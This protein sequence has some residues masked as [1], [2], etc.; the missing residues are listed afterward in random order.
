MQKISTCLWF[1]DKAEEAVHFYLSIFKE[2]RI[3]ATSH[4]GPEGP[5]PEGTVLTIQFEI[6]GHEFEALN[7]GPHFAFTPAISLIVNCETQEEVDRYWEALSEGG[8]QEMCGWLKDRYG[9]SWQIVPTALG[10]MMQDADPDRRS[11]VMK[12]M[13]QMQKLD[14]HELRLAY[15]G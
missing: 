13:L 7:G 6:N 8:S 11:R 9:L 1:D 2:G 12:A 15:E 4:Y 5:G 14:I 10:E 3:L